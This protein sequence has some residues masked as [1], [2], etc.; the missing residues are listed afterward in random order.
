VV[1]ERRHAISSIISFDVPD[2]E[3][4]DSTFGSDEDEAGDG[5][6]WSTLRCNSRHTV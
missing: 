6:V 5:G 3:C 1:K 4:G 2:D